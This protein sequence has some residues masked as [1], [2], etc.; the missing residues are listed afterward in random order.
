VAAKR[1]AKPQKAVS[2]VLSCVALL[3]EWG[4]RQHQKAFES[5][6]Q[7][8]RVVKCRYSAWQLPVHSV[9]SSSL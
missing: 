5:A 7:C 9:G 2:M 8:R 3:S 1:C 6:G 4:A